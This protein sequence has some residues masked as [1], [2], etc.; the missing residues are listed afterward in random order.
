MPATAEI[1]VPRVPV[2]LGT[3]G[4]LALPQVS[5]VTTLP[6]VE[7]AVAEP[8]G[9]A[10]ILPQ[11]GAAFQ[12]SAPLALGAGASVEGAMRDLAAGPIPDAQT[13]NDAETSREWAAHVFDSTQVRGAPQIV[14][15]DGHRF[16][17]NLDVR[18]EPG[19]KNGYRVGTYFFV[20]HAL[21]ITPASFTKESFY[22]HI[23]RRVRFKAPRMTLAEILDKSN[24]ASPLN[25]LTATLVG[26]RSGRQDDEEL[27][28]AR[29]GIQLLGAIASAAMRDQA[30][31]L[32]ANLPARRGEISALVSDARSLV[33]EVRSLRA[34]LDDPASPA[35]VRET[36]NFLDEFLSLSISEHFVPLLGAIRKDPALR[37]AL[38][39]EDHE[40][41]E[42]IQSEDAYRA[43]SGYPSV[44]D[45]ATNSE[46][47]FYRRAVLKNF[48]SS[49]LDLETKTDDW[50]GAFQV[51]FGL[52]AAVAMFV[53]L[54]AMQIVA[55]RVSPSGMAFVAI[56]ITAYVIKDRIKEVL[57]TWTTRRWR[58]F[59]SDAVT[60]IRDPGTGRTIGKARESFGFV[61]RAEVPA[62]VLRIRQA[63]PL[64]A[65]GE[66]G[67]PEDVLHY[68]K[69]VTIWPKAMA[70][71]RTLRRDLDDSLLINLLPFLENTE[72][73]QVGF[74]YLDP[75]T[76][77]LEVLPAS[78]V[79]HVNMVTRH[80]IL[81]PSDHK[82]SSYDRLRVVMDREGIKRIE[83]VPI[84]GSP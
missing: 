54:L 34:S 52:S 23:Q 26:A 30:R 15:H 57:R 50:S 81:Q 19:R 61:P 43:V 73:S 9:P 45:K 3:S 39:P 65:V 69:E 2:E 48:F 76:G 80:E 64:A 40:I 6:E 31:G 36:V 27:I 5:V 29:R 77:R 35:T 72:D 67:K 47:L 32:A 49:V 14:K 28:A 25:R 11:N 44:V 53:Y 7:T 68:E 55:G 84:P 75:G 63:D 70:R 24:E 12:P 20:P 82:A 51:L 83:R 41:A 18:L 66:D 71:F 74:D 37:E 22:Q 33:A 56:G 58:R 79:Y 42:L 78:R 4:G 21:G 38:A 59:F 8:F 10:A 60:A 46:A 16:E 62:E 1:V 17:L 13:S